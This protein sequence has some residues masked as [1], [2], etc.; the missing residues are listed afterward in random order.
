MVLEK[1][2]F[3]HGVMIKEWIKCQHYGILNGIGGGQ[4]NCRK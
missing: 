4:L 2:Y 3:K 1:T